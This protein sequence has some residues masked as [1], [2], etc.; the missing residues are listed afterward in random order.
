MLSAPSSQSPPHLGPA[1]DQSQALTLE[2]FLANPGP[3]RSE[4]LSVGMT[5][6]CPPKWSWLSA[7]WH[8]GGAHQHL[9]FTVFSKHYGDESGTTGRPGGP[10]SLIWT[11]VFSMSHWGQRPH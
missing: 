6:P 7:A 4:L 10:S 1:G 8:G 3:L 2:A 9:V 5:P 11:S